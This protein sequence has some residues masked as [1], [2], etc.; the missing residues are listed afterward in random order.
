MFSSLEPVLL[1]ELARSGGVAA[2]VAALIGLLLVLT[3][4]L[5]LTVTGD[6]MA[7]G[8]H[9][10]HRVVTCRAGGIA[11]LA[12]FV[13][14]VADWVWLSGASFAPDPRFAGLLLAA[15]VPVAACGIAEDLTKRVGP[16]QRL[17]WIGLGALLL[18]ATKTIWIGRVGI[19]A[20][21]TLLAAAPF[22]LAFTVVAVVGATNAF[23][24]VDGLDGL[25]GGVALITLAAI[26]WVARQ[27]GD[28]QVFGLA[29]LAAAATLAWLPFNW[30]RARLFAGDGGAYMLGFVCAVLLVVLVQRHPQVSPW[31]GLTVAALPVW[32]T[33]YS[34]W[35]RRS[36]AR[37]AMEADQCHLHQLLRFRVHQMLQHRALRCAGVWDDDWTPTEEQ[38]PRLPVSA[39]NGACSPILWVMHAAV[40][41]AGVVYYDD[42]AS[43]ILVFAGF[44]AVYVLVHRRLSRSRIRNRLA[45]AA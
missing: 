16:R 29:L 38:S 8:V 26:A 31:F 25:L 19:D 22:A 6:P 27:V 18:V 15:L 28:T 7:S 14:G 10:I 42:T 44:A 30:P 23:N 20:L 12:G 2:A 34:I 11:M 39:P 35:R 41:V 5:H 37:A 13:V 36:S 1:Q 4:R 45:L 40:A 33:L 21:D 24:I 9:K 3:R 17:F 43:S 32:E